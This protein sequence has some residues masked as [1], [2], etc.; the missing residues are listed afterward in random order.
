MGLSLQSG[1]D[2]YEK[3]RPRI[4]P[5]RTPTGRKRRGSL[6]RRRSSQKSGGDIQPGEGRVMGT[7]K[8]PSRREGSC[9]N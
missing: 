9:V 6:E 7:K 8:S 5:Q 3:T 2:V 4:K 1:R